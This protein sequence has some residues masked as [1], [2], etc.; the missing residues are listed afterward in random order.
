MAE[1]IRL[2]LDHSRAH[3]DCSAMV[4]VDEDGLCL[5]AVG[6]GPLDEIAVYSAMVGNKVE[7]F[8]GTLYSHDASFSVRI[9]RFTAAG[10]R[11]ILCA[12][13]GGGEPR[14]NSLHS[15]VGGVSRILAAA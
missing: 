13:G 7:N 14:A 2:Q 11:L 5:S 1:A 8:E 9:R 12:V 3:A 10:A 15:S 6:E 4:L